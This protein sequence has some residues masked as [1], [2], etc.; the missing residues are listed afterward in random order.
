MNEAIAQ[1]K[2]QIETAFASVPYPGDK[3]I[4]ATYDDEGVAEYFCRASWQ[5][6]PVEMLRYHSCAL[7]FF[8]PKAYHYYLPA[9]MLAELADAEAA[10]IIADC[11]VF[12]FSPSLSIGLLAERIAL[13]SRPQLTAIKAFIEYLIAQHGE[14]GSMDEANK[15]LANLLSL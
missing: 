11:I 7:S 6:H 12:D 2:S 15:Y 10:D 3:T 14:Y 1:L 9:F 13:F 4:T 8:T 5:G